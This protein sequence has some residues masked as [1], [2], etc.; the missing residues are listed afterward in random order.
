MKKITRKAKKSLIKKLATE[1]YTQKWIMIQSQGDFMQFG[2]GKDYCAFCA[3]ANFYMNTHECKSER[4]C[5]NCV[6]DHRLCGN[7][8]SI[9]H[10]LLHYSPNGSISFQYL[11]KKGKEGL[12]Q[13]MYA[14]VI[15]KW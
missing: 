12:V 6:I 7:R 9:F 14:G 11:L 15:K 3:D 1:S 10:K 5:D 2:D 4:L 8:N 13:L